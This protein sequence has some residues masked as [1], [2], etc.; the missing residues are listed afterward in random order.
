MPSRTPSPKNS[1]MTIVPS[2]SLALAVRLM[3]AGAMIMPL[4]AGAVSVTAGSALTLIATG[5]LEAVAFILRKM[6]GVA[7][8]TKL[9]D[10]SS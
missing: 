6:R 5:G 9:L 2:L 10:Q 3:L 7:R 8:K 1:T 4:L